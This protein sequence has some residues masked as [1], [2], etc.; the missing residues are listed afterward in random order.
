MSPRSKLC[1]VASGAASRK[2][3]EDRPALKNAVKKTL[4]KDHTLSGERKKLK[5]RLTESHAQTD[6]LKQRLTEVEFKS[7]LE[8][9]RSRQSDL[10]RRESQ[11]KGA[12]G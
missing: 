4:G 9:V 12:D 10:R 11:P 2:R 7:G 6:Q 8:G 1:T 5:Q 3:S